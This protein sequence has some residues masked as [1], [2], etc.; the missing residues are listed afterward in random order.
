MSKPEYNKLESIDEMFLRRMLNVQLST[1]KEIE[2][3]IIPIRYLIRMRRCMYWWQVVN[4]DQNKL[5]NKFYRAHKIK[6]NMVDWV[7]Q[8]EKR[9]K[10]D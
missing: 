2:P 3:E 10:G 8:L 6:P 7:D 1:P 4:L 9:Q 5:L